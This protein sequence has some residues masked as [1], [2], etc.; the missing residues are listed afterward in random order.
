M[1]HLRAT[2]PSTRC[3]RDCIRVE[4]VTWIPKAA[5][6][7]RARTAVLLVVPR[8]QDARGQASQCRAPAESITGLAG[9]LLRGN[10]RRRRRRGGGRASAAK[11]PDRL[12]LHAE[13]RQHFA[14]GRSDGVSVF[15][16]AVARYAVVDA[17]VI[18]LD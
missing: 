4:L 18:F 13:T 14:L 10:F 9:N 16:T 8:G 1:R 15:G 12:S 7:N 3:R 6:D 5:P 17:A 2:R 11:D